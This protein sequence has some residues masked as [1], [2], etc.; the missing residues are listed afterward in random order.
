MDAFLLRERKDSDLVSAYG[1]ALDGCGSYYQRGVERLIFLSVVAIGL[2]FLW[3]GCYLFFPFPLV[4]AIKRGDC[5]RVL[6]SLGVVPLFLAV[7]FLV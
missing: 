2:R 1:C 5:R 4:P 6:C 3:L 7:I